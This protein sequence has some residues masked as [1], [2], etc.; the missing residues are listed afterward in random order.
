[1]VLKIGPA[2]GEGAWDPVLGERLRRE[3]RV[4]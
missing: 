1:M 2:V 4:E 3:A